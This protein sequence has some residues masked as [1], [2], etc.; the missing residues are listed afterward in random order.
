MTNV[1]VFATPTQT[2]TNTTHYTDPY[3]TYMDQYN[4]Y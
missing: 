2:W 3:D 4:Y 1:N